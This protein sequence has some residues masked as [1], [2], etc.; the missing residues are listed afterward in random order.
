MNGT[1]THVSGVDF[2]SRGKRQSVGVGVGGTNEWQNGR[3]AV[4]G[5]VNLISATHNVSDNYSIGGTVGG[6]WV[7]K[8]DENSGN[9]ITLATDEKPFRP[10]V[11]RR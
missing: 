11:F 7:G 6:V 8:H 4:Y 2:S 10:T 5:N 9:G 3:Y 1:K